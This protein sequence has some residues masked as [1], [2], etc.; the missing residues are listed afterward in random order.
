MTVSAHSREC[1]REIVCCKSDMS[2][3]VYC[4]T[5]GCQEKHTFVWKSSSYLPNGAFLCNYR[6]SHGYFSSGLLPSQYE[7]FVEASGIGKISKRQMDYLVK[8]YSDCVA[9]EAKESCDQ[10]LAEEKSHYGEGEGITIITDARHGWRK[11]AKDTDVVCIGYESHKVLYNSHVTTVDDPCTQRHEILGTRRIYDHLESSKIKIST[12][13]HDSNA[14][15]NKFIRENKPATSNQNDTWHAG[16][17][18]KKAVC[19]I[20]KGAQYKHGVT[21]HRE[22]Q[23][24]ATNIITHVHWAMRN[25][26]NDPANLR[27]S[28]DNIV[29]H[30]QNIHESCHP[31][32]RCK[33][34]PNY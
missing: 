13:V 28:L 8:S 10:A 18:L 16:V 4:G 32:S 26:E 7:R 1:S 6:I 24:K 11:N 3:H 30:Y 2:G 17:S 14:S 31:S 21:W 19:A 34:D 33:T 5:F 29:N 27:N 12:H 15:I 22:L 9:K 23:D 25:C 20:T